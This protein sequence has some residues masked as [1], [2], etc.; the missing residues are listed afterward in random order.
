MHKKLQSASSSSQNEEKLREAA[1]RND[2]GVIRDL[3]ARK[4]N[5]NSRNEVRDFQLFKLTELAF[6]CNGSA[7]FLSSMKRVIS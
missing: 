1:Q 6:K 2:L 5:P 3:L 7:M 4:T